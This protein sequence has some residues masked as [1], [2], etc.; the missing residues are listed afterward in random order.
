MEKW[1][2]L[3]TE[4]D[5][6]IISIK[7]VVGVITVN[8][9]EW[10]GLVKQSHQNLYRLDCDGEFECVIRLTEMHIHGWHI[11]QENLT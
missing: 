11:L 10:K 2:L 3:S 6:Y 1:E 5:L 9:R 8:K 4:A 7:E